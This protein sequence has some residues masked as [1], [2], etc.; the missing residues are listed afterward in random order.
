M[1]SFFD[2]MNGANGTSASS[3]VSQ[4]EP[5]FQISMERKWDRLGSG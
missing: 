1:T 5:V 3:H 2:E 4:H